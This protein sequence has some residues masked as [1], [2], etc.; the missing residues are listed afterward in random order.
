[1]RTIVTFDGYDLTQECHVS[2]LRR[3]MLARA[4]GSV[5]VPGMDGELST[6]QRLEAFDLGLTLTIMGRDPA[7]RERQR[8]RVASILDTV[9]EGQLAISEDDGL[10]YKARFQGTTDGERSV[11]A[12][13]FDATF[14]ISD[15]VRYGTLRTVTVPSEGSVTFT[16]GGTYQTMPT[17]SVVMAAGADGEQWRLALEDGSYL[18]YEP[19]YS[20]AIAT[21]S[22]TFDC[23]ARLLTSGG[24]ARMLPPQADWLTLSPGEHTLTMTSDAQTGDATVTFWERWL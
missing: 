17:V 4:L 23:A 20:G 14:R 15:P 10:F 6:G 18:L 19:N 5:D 16:V 21:E 9:G 24:Y 3:P 1:M 8:Q 13:S 2:G 22:V 11:N 7:C 12:E